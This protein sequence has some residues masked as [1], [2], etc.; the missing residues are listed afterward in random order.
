M[1]RQKKETKNKKVKIS[2]AIDY[3]N[4]KKINENFINKSKFVN[5]LLLQYFNEIEKGNY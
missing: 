5:W 2:V 3:E 4:E 1:G